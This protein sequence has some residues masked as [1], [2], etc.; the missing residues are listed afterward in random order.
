MTNAFEKSILA[1]R[2]AKSTGAVLVPL[3]EQLYE[4]EVFPTSESDYRFL[5]MLV[6]ARGLPRTANVISPSMLGSCLRKVFFAATGVEKYPAHTAR[7]YGYFAKGN[8]THLQWQFALWKAHEAGLLQLATVA[9]ELPELDFYGDGSRPAVE[10]RVINERGDFGGTLDALVEIDKPYVV[11]F[12][13]IRLDDYMRTVR[14]GASEEYQHQIVGYALAVNSHHTL[15]HVVK[16][17]LLVAEC[18]AGPINGGSP[19][20]LHETHVRV[21]TYKDVVRARLTLVRE[22]IG[23]NEIPAPAC[24]SVRQADYQE[25]PYSRF[26]TAEVRAAQRERERQA[27]G[28]RKPFQIARSRR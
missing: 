10:L 7:T 2:R 1:R 5:D 3:L 12:K 14:D 25:C 17:C 24:V 20:A 23:R 19:L 16:D 8:F 11:D 4:D 21:D 28:A 18:K 6:R 26:C 9:A 27:R 13:G 22:H 15:P